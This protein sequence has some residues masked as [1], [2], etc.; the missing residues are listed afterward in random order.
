MTRRLQ[1]MPQEA[2]ENG[3]TGTTVVVLM[4]G[5]DGKIGEVK[6]AQSSG[7]DALDQQARIAAS[8]AKSFAATPPQLLGKPF[9]VRLSLKFE[10]PD[11][12]SGVE[13]NRLVQTK[14]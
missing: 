11:E 8:R 12:N 4:M 7:Y 3:W 1:R 6:I 14:C 10:A 13:S 5:V 9:E 2:M